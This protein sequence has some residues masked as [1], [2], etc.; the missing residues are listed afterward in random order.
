MEKMK[1]TYEDYLGITR[2]TGKNSSLAHNRTVDYCI[3]T[4]GG[5]RT[6]VPLS[7]FAF[8]KAAMDAL[9]MPRPVHAEVLPK[10]S[11]EPTK[12]VTKAEEIFNSVMASVPEVKVYHT[13]AGTVTDRRKYTH[14]TSR[15]SFEEQVW[16]RCGGDQELANAVMVLADRKLKELT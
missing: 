8:L 5:V 14:H 15:I 6:Q 3:M 2:V 1:V 7:E 10:E 9:L 12:A 4:V 13:K 16:D 11:P